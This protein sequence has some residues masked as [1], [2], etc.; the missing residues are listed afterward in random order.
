MDFDVGDLDG[1]GENEYVLI[2]HYRIMVYKLKKG[3]L[4]KIQ[5]MRTQK[6]INQLIGVDV[7][8]I[9]GNGRDE[10]FVT[11]WKGDK[12][13]SFALER[14]VRK[15]RLKYVWKDVNLYF[16][17]IRPFGQKPTLLSQS[18]GFE[19]PFIGPIKKVVFKNRRYIQGSKLNTP[20]IYGIHFI[21]YGLTQ[22]NLGGN[23][24]K[25]TVVLDNNYHLRVYSPSGKVIVKSDA[26]Y[27][28]DPR[29]IEVGVVDEELGN[30][31]TGGGES[32][33]REGPVRYKG[34][35]QF[36]KN[37]GRRFLVL[38]K[39]YVAGGGLINQLVI[40]NNSGLVIL[41]VNREGFEKVLES[42][43]QK[44]FLAAFRVVPRKGNAGADVHILRT[45]RN[46]IS[47]AVSGGMSE[48]L[49]LFLE[50]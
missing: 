36:V 20:D 29:L 27:G 10:I 47:N 50:S 46:F 21:L 5:Q 4:R 44:G 39:N 22:A 33:G 1:D 7:G 3:K 19:T 38:P 30:L 25:E 34:R 24:V 28:H 15:K 48:F 31:T 49:N 43:K 17:I 42:N 8:D 14:Q 9:N 26:Y 40:V 41:G 37:G 35:L 13:E 32:V 18:P 11:S 23:K 12:L 6:G 2:D 16:R 45:E